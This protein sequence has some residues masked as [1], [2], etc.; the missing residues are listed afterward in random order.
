MKPLAF[1]LALAVFAPSAYP[2]T[3]QPARRPA[4]PSARDFQTTRPPTSSH[5]LRVVRL[6]ARVFTPAPGVDVRLRTYLQ[7]H[8]SESRIHVLLQFAVPPGLRERRRLEDEFKSRLLDPVPERAFF[9]SVPPDFELLNRLVGRN[10]PALAVSLIEPNDKISPLLRRVGV[11]EHARR[12]GGMAELIVQFFGDVEQKRQEQL[13]LAAEAKIIVRVV[14]LNGWRITIDEKNIRRLAEQDAVKW[15]E[16]IPAPPTDDNDGVRAASGVNADAILAPTLYNLTGAGVTV[17]QWETTHASQTHADF[18]GRISVGDPPVPLSDR[19]Q[20]H[21]ET[22][23]VNNQFDNTEGVY[24]D[25]DDSANVSAGDVRETAIGAFAA[26]ST[27]AAGDADA[28]GAVVF[29]NI[30]ERFRDADADTRLDAGEGVYRDNDGS[31]FSATGTVSVGDTRLTPVGAFAAGSVVAAGDADIGQA[32]RSFFTNPHD[33]A[34][35]VAG[36]VMGSGAQSAANG[37]GPNQWKG[38]APGATLRTYDSPVLNAEYVNA[39]ANNVAISTNSWGTSHCHQVFPPST[40]YDVGSQSYDGI[41]SG[42]Q[43]DGTPSGLARRILISGSSGNQGRPERH[44]EN[45]AVGG[46]FNSGESVYRDNDDNGV[47]SASDTLVIGPA[48]PAGTALVNFALNERHADPGSNGQ[49]ESAEGVYLDADNSRTVTVGDTRLTATGGFAAG[50]VVAAGNAD[51]ATNLRQFRLWG[52]LRIPNSAKDTVEVANI[53]SD[54]NGLNPSSSRGPTD[55]GRTKPDIAGPGS[56]N[57]GDGGVTSA[58]PRNLYVVNAGTSMSTPAVS[59]VAA[60]VTEWYASSCVA[61]GPSPE[62]VKALLLHGAQDLTN[63]PNVGAGFNG[64]DFAFGYGRAR[65]KEAVDLIP[66]HR[67]G[68]AAALGDTDFVVT[69][70]RMQPLKVTLA[71]DDPAWTANAAPSAVTG[72]LQNDLDLLLIAPDGT[73]YTP[74]VLNAAAPGTAATRSNFPAA[75]VIPVAARDRRNTVEQVTVDNAMPGA[76][77][78]RVTA[79]TLNLPSQTYTIVSEALPP[80]AGPCAATPAANVRMRDNAGDGGAVPSGGTMWL[81]PD[82]WNRPGPDGLT[83]HQNPEFGQENFIYANIRNDLAGTAATKAISLDF[84][85]APA[86]TG[87]AWPTNFTYVGRIS[88]PNLG[89]GEVRQ[90]GP[91]AWMPPNPMPSDHFC[92]YVR[93]VSPQD[94]ITF[95]ETADV[96]SNAANSN[97]LVWRNIN[98]VNIL[99]SRSVTFLARNIERKAAPVDSDF[100]RPGEAPTRWGGLCASVAGPGETLA[101]AE[102]QG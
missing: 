19:S 40:C 84:W 61:A 67:I 59:G 66:H 90:V 35:H 28:G 86:A 8:T 42:R 33:Y 3:S 81:S 27:V 62:T 15:I 70:G 17:G 20:V 51:V 4:S 11:P 1:A 2:Q 30:L 43:S 23:A 89:I 46:V 14:E 50:S 37:G 94:P 63:I 26:G 87:L 10:G 21:A 88:V 80:Q 101:D 83:I 102:P 99:S 55:D 64:P 38:V 71:W 53:T 98:V 60:L 73:Q 7:K 29:F 24:W 85:L 82:V 25:F 97:N 92:F 22:V 9:A 78:I 75:A 69:V 47:V 48:Q 36:T 18:A 5:D 56:Q 95:A 65:A 39:A 16:E 31:M 34:T 12:K 32:I 100:H 72:I 76:W 91:L 74:W 58:L 54:A 68:T 6:K 41:V 44:A 57:G 96:G 49:F 77:T 13:L 45:V 52:N 79:S 93:V